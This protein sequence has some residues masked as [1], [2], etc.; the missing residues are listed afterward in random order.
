MKIKKAVL[1]Q[2]VKH[3]VQTNININL[4]ACKITLSQVHVCQK[5]Q[6]ACKRKH[7]WVMCLLK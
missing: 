6:Q 3:C 7:I 5:Q 4:E 2:R 1:R